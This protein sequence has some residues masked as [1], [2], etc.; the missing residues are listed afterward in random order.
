M[1]LTML[2][3]S[4]RYYGIET[5]IYV[6]PEGKEIIYLRRRFLP[7]LER[8]ALLRE[9]LVRQGERPDLVAGLEL[10]DAELTWRLCDGN[11]VLRPEELTDEPG[12]LIRI[13]LPENV[14]G[15]PNA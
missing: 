10:G 6:S 13:T 4:S 2:P 3:P 11:P 7:R 8:L 1:K 9:H 15:M 5:A 12:R 14:P